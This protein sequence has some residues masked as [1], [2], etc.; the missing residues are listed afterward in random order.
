MRKDLTDI[1]VV[2]DRSGSMGICKKEAEDGLN[3]FIEEQKKQ[4]G[5]ATFTLVQFDDQY[6]VVHSA[7][8]I[9]QVPFCHLIP[10]GSTA[11]LDAVAKAI[12]ATGERLKNMT[13]NQ[14]PGLVVFVIVTDGQEN[15]S[16]EY[17]KDQ[18]KQMIEHQQ[19]IYKWQFTFLGANQDAF[20]EAA[21]I[22]IPMAAA[23]NYSV[24]NSDKAFVGASLNLSR[25][26]HYTAVGEE[27][28]SFYSDEERKN[29]A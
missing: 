13:E 19:N 8:P 12:N 29:M 1:T 14:R 2:L 25:M 23:A 7:M 5:E 24:Q 3:K 26:R 28:K 22:G 27:A 11:L 6:E 20:S 15:A 16:K 10:R 9:K 21:S 17:K 18:I 4:P